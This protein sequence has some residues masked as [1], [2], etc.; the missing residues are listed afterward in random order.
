MHFH[1]ENRVPDGLKMY[2]D[3]IESL[4]DG[5]RPSRW[6]LV[7]GQQDI[8]LCQEGIILG[9]EHIILCQKDILPDQE[10]ILLGQ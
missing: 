10:D 7:L 9:Q 4:F 8:L 3:H 1:N 6:S 2:I 5:L